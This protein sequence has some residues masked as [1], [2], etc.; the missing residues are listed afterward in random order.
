MPKS[1]KK[2]KNM[3]VKGGVVSLPPGWSSQTDPSTGE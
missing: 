1:E 3:S 2:E